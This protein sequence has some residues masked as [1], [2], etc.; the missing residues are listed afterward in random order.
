MTLTI[1]RLPNLMVTT[2][3]LN[4]FFLLKCLFFSIGYEIVQLL[5]LF[6]IGSNQAKSK[7]ESD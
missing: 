7:H 6:D 4:G 3:V 5:H 2:A 1:G